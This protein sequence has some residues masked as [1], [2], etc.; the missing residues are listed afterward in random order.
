[1]RVLLTILVGIDAV[2]ISLIQADVIPPD[3]LSIFIQLPL[4][5][6]F[7]WYVLRKDKDSYER[8][9]HMLEEQDKRHQR[10]AELREKQYTRSIDLFEKI[11][12]RQD[13]RQSDLIATLARLENTL[14][15]N[16]ATVSESIKMSELVDELKKIRE[17]HAS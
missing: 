17:D 14:T 2:Y 3:L 9:N 12:D 7:A 1:M 6:L 5:G 4:I 13:N 11:I 10:D 16:T 15:L 8:T